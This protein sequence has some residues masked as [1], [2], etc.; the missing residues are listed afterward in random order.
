MNPKD[1]LRFIAKEAR[2]K[3][4]DFKYVPK[5]KIKE[6]PPPKFI[7]KDWKTKGERNPIAAI[8]GTMPDHLRDTVFK[9]GYIPPGK[10]GT[11]KDEVK[12]LE[13]FM[14]REDVPFPKK[15]QLLEAMMQLPTVQQMSVRE[16]SKALPGTYDV[17]SW[18][19]RKNN[20][21]IAGTESALY[22]ARK[23]AAPVTKHSQLALEQGVRQLPWAKGQKPGPPEIGHTEINPNR[24]VGEIFWQNKARNSEAEGYGTA[25]AQDAAAFG[26][27]EAVQRNLAKKANPYDDD[28]EFAGRSGYEEG[29]EARKIAK[30]KRDKDQEF[31]EGYNAARSRKVLRNRATTPVELPFQ[32]LDQSGRNRERM[33]QAMGGVPREEPRPVRNIFKAE[34]DAG[35]IEK[36]LNDA[37]ITISQLRAAARDRYLPEAGKW[38][39]GD[40]E[41]LRILELLEVGKERGPVPD[42]ETRRKNFTGVDKATGEVIEGTRLPKMLRML[43][44]I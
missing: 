10:T 18:S 42:L 17:L 12:A 22:Q 13:L 41:A 19:V 38:A 37:G 35:S 14:R 25:F 26:Y 7:E 3:A 33:K 27:D 29:A 39:K 31:E 44:L 6:E 43:G 16:M 21:T 32:G 20:S 4:R 24:K 11:L 9:H 34:G 15:M 2:T 30:E 40:P 5:P 1:V 23:M 8:L 28:L 36:S